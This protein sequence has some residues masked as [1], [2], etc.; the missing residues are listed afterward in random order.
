MDIMEMLK[1]ANVNESALLEYSLSNIR[2]AYGAIQKKAGKES[3]KKY[4]NYIRGTS[5]RKG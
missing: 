3:F 4:Q 1:M 5:D 2:S